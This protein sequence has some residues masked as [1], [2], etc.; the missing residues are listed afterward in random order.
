MVH[1]R[2]FGDD[3]DPS[4]EL[5]KS[6]RQAKTRIPTALLSVVLWKR[7]RFFTKARGTSDPLESLFLFVRFT[8][9]QGAQYKISKSKFATSIMAV[10]PA[11]ES[12]KASLAS[13]RPTNLSAF[14]VIVRFKN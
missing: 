3:R 10:T 12:T 5:L 2:G 1:V 9:S 8:S 4:P 11:T 7:S 14:I 13:L 6:S